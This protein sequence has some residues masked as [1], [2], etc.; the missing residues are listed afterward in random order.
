MSEHSHEVVA[1]PSAPGVLRQRDEVP[2]Q[3]SSRVG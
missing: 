2:A 1:I 3:L